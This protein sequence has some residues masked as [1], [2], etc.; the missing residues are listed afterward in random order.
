[1][2]DQEKRFFELAKYYEQLKEQMK[3]VRSELDT[4]ME[5]LGVNTYHQDPETMAVYRI[6]VP[7]GTFVEFKTISYDRT[8]LGSEARGS[9]SK[10]EAEDNGF[11]LSK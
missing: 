1:M 3:K 5:G 4:V 6:S 8:K 9:L 11:V 2:T 10:K 7:N